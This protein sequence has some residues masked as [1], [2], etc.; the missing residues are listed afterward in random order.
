M[1]E[2]NELDEYELSYLE[3]PYT[4]QPPD[5]LSNITSDAQEAH[6]PSRYD[7]YE[8]VS[9]LATD[10]LEVSPLRPQLPDEPSLFPSQLP[11]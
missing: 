11:S 5:P 3:M 9:R 1:Q 7:S 6:E 2:K 10:S 8:Q 4:A